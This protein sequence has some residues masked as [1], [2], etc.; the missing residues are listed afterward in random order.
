MFADTPFN[1]AANPAWAWAKYKPDERRPWS[2]RLAGHLYRRAA[3][4]GTWSQLE[5]ALAD[6]PQ[7]TVDRLLRPQTDVAAFNETYD[8]Y[9]DAA[10]SSAEGLR[11]WWLRRMIE[12]PHPLLE[13]MTLFWH[14]HFAASNARVKSGQLMAAHVRMLRT[15]A[16]GKYRPLLEG[17]SRD[18]AMFLGLDSVANRKSVPNENFARQL[19][20]RLTLGPGHFDEEDVHEAARAFTGW[21]VMRNQ[22]RFVAREHDEGTKKILGRAGKWTVEDVVQI[23]LDQPAVSRLL[24]RKLYRWLISETDEPDDALL[25]PIVESFDKDYDVGR[26]VET[27]LRSN[28]FFSE[29]AYRRRVKSP[30]EYA[31]GIIRALETTVSTVRLGLHLS[32]LGQNLLYPPTVR[33]WEGGRHWLNSLTLVGRSNLAT[34]LLAAEGPYGGKLDPAAVA[35]RHNRSAPKPAA[36]FVVDLFLQG[37]LG[38]KVREALLK[39]IPSSGGDA[40]K[41]LRPFV[42][43]VVTLPEFQ[44]C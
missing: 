23:V 40:S 9:D 31:L 30:I 22:L 4:G 2:L 25:A 16:L 44:L 19:M 1:T 14:G 10:A 15:H 43:G 7:R 28:L 32:E 21:F 37:D 13:K 33:G 39:A 12:T 18:P 26:V 42:H 3:F 20:E 38:P 36:E 24:V 27:M 5:Q 8:E 6:G 41:W 29:T 17:A 11:S 35:G 34:A